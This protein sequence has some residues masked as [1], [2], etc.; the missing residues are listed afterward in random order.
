MGYFRKFIL[1]IIVC[2]L[3]GSV[4]GQVLDHSWSAIVLDMDDSWYATKEAQNIADNVLLYQKDIGGWHKNTAMHKSLSE[5]EK[6]QLT[7]SKSDSNRCTIDNGATFLEMIYLSKVYKKTKK[8]VYKDAFLNGLDYILEAQYSNGGWPQYYPLRQ[9]YYSHITYNDGAMVHMMNILNDIN[10]GSKNLGIQVDSATLSKTKLAFNKGLSCI[11][12]TQYKQHGTLTGWCAQ[13]DE[14]TF[15]PAKARAYEL[16]SLGGVDTAQIVSLLMTIENPSDDVKRSIEAAVIWLE[17]TKITGLKEE[18]YITTEG[19][20]EKR[21]VKDPNAK[22]LWARFMD[23]EDN[24]PFFCDRDGIKKASIMDIKQERRAGYAWYNTNPNQVLKQYPTWKKNLKPHPKDSYNVTVAQDGSA[25]Y[26]N[27]QDAINN[28]KAFPYDR[29]TIFI[30]KGIYRE[31]VHVYEW[32]PKIT[33]IGEDKAETIITYNDYF[34]SV[35]LG[36]NSTFHTSTVLVE[37]NYTQIKNLTIENSAGAV[38]QAIALSVGAN[39]CVIENCNILGNQDTV[40]LTGEQNKQWFKNCLITGTTDFI[41]GNAITLF[42]DCEIRSKSDSFIT[43]A[44]TARLS[45]YGFVFKNCT[46]TANQGVTNVY[47]GRPWR[48]YAKT[49]FMNCDLGKHIREEGWHNWNKPEAE[50][51]GFYAEYKNYGEGSPLKNRV[52]WSHQLTKQEA[53]TYSIQNILGINS[54]TEWLK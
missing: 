13:H 42:S 10:T 52:K 34:D 38:G 54:E 15:Q 18:R 27:I 6:L 7:A 5:E 2:F 43:A 4:Q 40:Y 53:E 44:S 1:K 35:N 28:S 36:R 41:F 45:K 8:D 48:I 30:K 25:D 12:K 29:I 9:G 26:N 23:L 24:T 22:P 47:L 51:L 20:K 33:L 31:K 39:A 14:V 17:K 37:G 21:Y 3:V 50:T 46:L 16:P 32:N 11:I 19:L 49:V